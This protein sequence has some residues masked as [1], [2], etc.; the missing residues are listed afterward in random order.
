MKYFTYFGVIVFIYILSTLDFTIL[1]NQFQNIEVIYLTIAF[2]LNFPMI[3]FKSYRW[4]QILKKQEVSISPKKSFEYYMSSLY[5]G[6]ITPGRIGEFSRVIYIKNLFKDKDYGSIFSSV[7]LDRLFD[8][9]L[10]VI[11]TIV[12]FSY[13]SL[14]IDIIYIMMFLFLF[15]ILPFII[16]QTSLFITILNFIASKLSDSFKEKTTQFIKIFVLTMKLTVSSGNILSFAIF[17]SLSYMIFFTQAYLIA[18]ALGI[19]ISLLVITFIMAISNTISLLPISVSGIGT[20]D[21]TL[22]YFLT[23]LGISSEISVLYSTFI[24]LVFFIGCSLIGFFYSIRNPISLNLV[25]T[26]NA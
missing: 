24:L 12:G 25:K 1:Y 4:Q 22:I 21:I 19:N 11:L 3:Y 20:R 18:L 14:S 7:V 5:L 15:F 8:L 13:L 2:L 10:L 17:T 6:F 16:I 23:P 26:K 9:Y